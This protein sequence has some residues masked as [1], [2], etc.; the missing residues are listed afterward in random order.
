MDES[1]VLIC[2]VYWENIQLIGIVPV[3]RQ[4]AM[5]ALALVDQRLVPQLASVL[6]FDLARLLRPYLKAPN[7][8][9]VF[10]DEGCK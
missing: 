3:V 7:D 5:R 4:Y 9:H 6:V 2:F 10:Q 1:H 8:V